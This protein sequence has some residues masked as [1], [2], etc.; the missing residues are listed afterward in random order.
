MKKIRNLGKI[1]NAIKRDTPEFWVKKLDFID[2]LDKF[3]IDES[4]SNPSD[5][6][7]CFLNLEKILD[8]YFIEYDNDWK[9][10]IRKI[11]RGTIKNI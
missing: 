8:L 9:K 4:Y 7:V 5:Y 3:L 2:R 10:R 1:V 6:N 11:C